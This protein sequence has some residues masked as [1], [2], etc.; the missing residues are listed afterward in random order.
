[1]NKL[2]QMRTRQEQRILTLV[3]TVPVLMLGFRI[4]D[5]G[6]R[7]ARDILVESLAGIAALCLMLHAWKIHKK[8]LTK[9]ILFGSASALL[10][11]AS[12]YY[13][14]E[15]RLL[16]IMV[17]AAPLCLEGLK[18]RFVKRHGKERASLSACIAWMVIA[19]AIC[20]VWSFI[21]GNHALELYLLLL[22]ELIE[23]A[24]WFLVIIRKYS[25]E[26]ER[27]KKL[28]RAWLLG[29]L[30]CYWIL[31]EKSLSGM[32]YNTPW[33]SLYQ[34]GIPL[35]YV[36]L[37][38]FLK[39]QKLSRLNVNLIYYT[40]S[41][42]VFH[43]NMSWWHYGPSCEIFFLLMPLIVYLGEKQR[44]SKTI[45]DYVLPP[46]YTIVCSWMTFVNSE[47][48]RMVLYDLGGPAIDIPSSPRADWLQY[49]FGALKSFFAGNIY[50]Y[51]GQPG[52][53]FINNN[54]DCS[55]IE[56]AVYPFFWFYAFVLVLVAAAAS[57]LL[58]RMHWS[59]EALNRSKNYLVVSY[60]LR[61]AIHI[62]GTLFLYNVSGVGFPFAIY[63]LMDFL[64]LWLL[65]ERN[66]M[67]EVRIVL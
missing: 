18:R 10:L 59:N 50:Y 47:R 45:S 64:I 2:I 9:G 52:L 26:Q 51:E 43:S 22:V 35:L 30:F 54:I 36:W 53:Q 12:D 60:L 7:S 28:W 41:L 21:T 33:Y 20:T 56:E 14:E 49:R 66:R 8:S 55:K 48:L 32:F 40:F 24:G 44:G 23:T 29:L 39:E 31:G 65:L 46:V 19:A 62:P 42:V 1:M 16:V 57:V 38:G 6:W 34:A 25:D 3:L 27:A 37:L 58:L 15:D 63:S 61:A 4:L 17:M 13:P 67:M 5:G 11:L